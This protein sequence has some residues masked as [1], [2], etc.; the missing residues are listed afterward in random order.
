MVGKNKNT[1]SKII[2][3]VVVETENVATVRQLLVEALDTVH[4]NSTVF[5]HTM[6]DEVTTRPDN[7][8]DYEMN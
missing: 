4:D 7:A 8:D 3:E 2:L 1:Y 5:S 6:A